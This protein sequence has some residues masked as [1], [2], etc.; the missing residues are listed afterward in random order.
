MRAAR[1]IVAGDVNVAGDSISGQTV[2]VQRGFSAK[3]V[4]R[5]ILI[6]GGLVFVTAACVFCVWRSFGDC[7]SERVTASAGR[8]VK[9][10]RSAKDGAKDFRRSSH[11]HGDNNFR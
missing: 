7:G 4:Q 6:V 9:T 11:F 5:L 2:S 1:E 8:R 3:E 10:R